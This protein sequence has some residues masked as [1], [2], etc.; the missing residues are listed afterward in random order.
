M[1]SAYGANCEHYRSF[2]SIWAPCCC[3]YVS[4]RQCHDKAVSHKL[5]RSEISHVRCERC[6]KSDQP[7]SSSCVACHKPFSEYFCAKCRL[8]AADGVAFHCE[9]CGIC[10]AGSPHESIH[11]NTCGVCVRREAMDKHICRPAILDGDCPVCCESLHDSTEDVVQTTC[12]H[13]LHAK[14][15]KI[16][17]A[18]SDK[19]PVCRTPIVR[20]KTN[21]LE[22]NACSMQSEE[23]VPTT[24]HVFEEE[25]NFAKLSNCAAGS[26]TCGLAVS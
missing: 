1:P 10:R 17:I 22:N 20:A 21:V 25:S 11:C 14:C 7:V 3:K 8:Y 26:C 18:Y 12:G 16:I 9:K 5:V 6:N 23:T 19:C 15:L 2:C 13:A 24:I 4:C